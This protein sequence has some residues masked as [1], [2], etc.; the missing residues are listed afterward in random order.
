MCGLDSAGILRPGCVADFVVVP[1]DPARLS[2]G[3]IAQLP[4]TAT[5]TGG[6][7]AVAELLPC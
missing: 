6:I 5:W 1:V 3:E 7:A 2:A 4:V